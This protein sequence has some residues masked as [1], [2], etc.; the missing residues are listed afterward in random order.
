MGGAGE[1]D[2][3][4]LGGLTLYESTHSHLLFTITLIHTEYA[5]KGQGQQKKCKNDKMN[6]KEN[7]EKKQHL[8]TF[9]KIVKEFI[10]HTVL[11]KGKEAP[12]SP[13]EHKRQV[14]RSGIGRNSPEELPS[15]SS[16]WCPGRKSKAA[17]C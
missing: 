3:L 2:S 11:T 15:A 13:A 16:T 12:S 9:I 4:Q 1:G 7:N 6:L 5:K 14:A 8:R 17:K 10:L